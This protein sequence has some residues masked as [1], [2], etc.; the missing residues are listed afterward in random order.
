MLSDLIKVFD[1]NG[2]GK[3]LKDFVFGRWMVFYFYLKDNIFGC[4]IEVKEFS[5]FIEEFEKF[6]V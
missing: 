1:E 4:I 6:G 3:F 5:E 2:E